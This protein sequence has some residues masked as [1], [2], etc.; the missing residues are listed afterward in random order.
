MPAAF[1]EERSM[2]FGVPSAALD[3]ARSTLREGGSLS[4]ALAASAEDLSLAP[5]IPMAT[6]IAAF[7]HD[8]ESVVRSAAHAD[9]PRE[10]VDALLAVALTV[11]QRFPEA[12]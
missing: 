7:Q 10:T 11:S 12:R 6:R 9:V 1:S 3:A 2:F 8:L 4:A 5:L